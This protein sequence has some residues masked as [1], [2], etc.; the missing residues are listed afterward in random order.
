MVRLTD[1]GRKTTTTHNTLFYNMRTS[2]KAISCM[3]GEGEG[4][5]IVLLHICDSCSTTKKDASWL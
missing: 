2:S 4:G 3:R 1:S 5:E